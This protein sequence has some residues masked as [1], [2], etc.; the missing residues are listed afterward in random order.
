MA[1]NNDVELQG[2]YEE[3]LVTTDADWGTFAWGPMPQWEDPPV[4]V[5]FVS[6]CF[7]SMSLTQVT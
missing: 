5:A 3:S 1:E 7:H 6:L 4:R 2:L